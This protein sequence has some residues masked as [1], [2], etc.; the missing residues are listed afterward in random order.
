MDKYALHIQDLLTVSDFAEA[1]VGLLSIRV[2][3]SRALFDAH[4]RKVGDAAH[5]EG[6][7]DG[8]PA[9]EGGLVSGREGQVVGYCGREST[10]K[11]AFPRLRDSVPLLEASLRNL[12]K[13][14]LPD[15]VP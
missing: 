9:G 10:G 8:A 13:N 7:G 2:A 1:L 4:P 11:T 5:V 6:L 12:A 14:L 3:V 15:F